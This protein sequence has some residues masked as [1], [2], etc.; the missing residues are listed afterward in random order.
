MTTL[1]DKVAVNIARKEGA[2]YNKNEGVDIVTP[3][4]AIEVETANT[5][6]EGLRQLQGFKKP[7]Y[8]A[9]VDKETE[10]AALEAT[11][12]T[13]IG[14]MDKNRNIIKKSTRKRS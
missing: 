4:R 1:H 9:A 12:G 13:T 14:V 8:I 11:E 7:V 5:V 2:E 3:K 6:K 10:K